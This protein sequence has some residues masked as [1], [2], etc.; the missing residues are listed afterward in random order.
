MSV[1]AFRIVG[2]ELTFPSDSFL[3]ILLGLQKKVDLK[4]ILTLH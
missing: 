3:L 2:L 1:G 4:E